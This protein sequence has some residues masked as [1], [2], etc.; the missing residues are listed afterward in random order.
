VKV[1]PPITCPGRFHNYFW[2]RTG[3]VTYRS[4]SVEMDRSKGHGNA[5]RTTLTSGLPDGF[6]APPIPMITHRSHGQRARVQRLPGSRPQLW[7]QLTTQ[8]VRCCSQARDLLAGHSVLGGLQRE[9][10]GADHLGCEERGPPPP[11]T[12][13]RY[14]HERRAHTHPHTQ[15]AAL[16][17]RR[18][19]IDQP[20][21]LNKTAVWPRWQHNRSTDCVACL[22]QP[23]LEGGGQATAGRPA[24]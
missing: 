14:Q 21:R 2:T 24:A 19:A 9:G 7:P 11:H 15:T 22:T 10:L 8:K 5:R 16:M 20:R 1:V 4:I 18:A 12:R 17:V 23:I 13:G 6:Q 3:G